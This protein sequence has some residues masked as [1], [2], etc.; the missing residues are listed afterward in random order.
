LWWIERLEGGEGVASGLASL[1]VAFA[2]CG[3]GRKAVVSF[4]K[5]VTFATSAHQSR[6]LQAKV[7]GEQGGNFRECRFTGRAGTRNGSVCRCLI[8]SVRCP[9]VRVVGGCKGAKP[10]ATR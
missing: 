1:W 2:D 3:R 5:A 9:L 4:G 8:I 6:S 10:P 7:V